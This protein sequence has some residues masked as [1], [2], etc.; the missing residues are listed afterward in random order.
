MRL[1]LRLPLRP[2]ERSPKF[3]KGPT[4]EDELNRLE[5]SPPLLKFRFNKKYNHD[6]SVNA[7]FLCNEFVSF[8]IFLLTNKKLGFAHTANQL[9]FFLPHIK[10]EIGGA[11]DKDYFFVV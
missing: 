1:P 6:I 10:K 8:C 5:S 11:I 4:N 9:L 7:S 2:L 3:P